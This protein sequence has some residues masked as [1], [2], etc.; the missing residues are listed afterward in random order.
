MK[1]PRTPTA[2]FLVIT[3]EINLMF[4]TIVYTL[5]VSSISPFKLI[6]LTFFWFIIIVITGM[7]FQP[8]LRS[9]IGILVPFFCIPASLAAGI[10][11]ADAYQLKTGKH[12]KD[13]SVT[14]APVH[15]DATV[16]YFR[17]G[18]LLEKC[19]GE[20]DDWDSDSHNYHY[21]VPYVSENWN[22]D[23]PVTVWITCRNDPANCLNKTGI[24][25]VTGRHRE[26]VADAEKQCGLNSA[27]ASLMVS[28]IEPPE[29]VIS[30]GENYLKIITGGINALWVIVFLIQLIRI[31]T[32]SPAGSF[33][34]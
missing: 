18:K 14:E 12:V 16:I 3:A 7:F 30:E 1:I 17:D 23:D 29:I 4:F 21:A 10:F 26:A 27:P 15:F 6:P 25:M 20:Y 32:G 8:A 13:V 11:Y 2:A 33:S 5:A 24:A 9:Y 28:W 22:G 19:T 31:K 34:D